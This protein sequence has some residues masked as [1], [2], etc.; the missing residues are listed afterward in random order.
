MLNFNSKVCMD[1]HFV[2]FWG[3]AP[4]SILILLL[5]SGSPFMKF[6][7]TPLDGRCVDIVR[8][9]YTVLSLSQEFYQNF[10]YEKYG[11]FPCTLI[12][13]CD[14]CWHMGLLFYCIYSYIQFLKYF[15]LQ[16][17]R[18]KHKSVTLLDGRAVTTGFLPAVIDEKI[19]YF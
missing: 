9:G 4:S 17:D 15:K 2:R 18:L 16:L 13:C 8:L 10:E 5:E 7:A 3:Y 11:H 12:P 19:I 1:V 14:L 6:L